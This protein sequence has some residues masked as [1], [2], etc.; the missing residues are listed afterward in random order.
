M[1]SIFRSDFRSFYFL[2]AT[3]FLGALNDN[4]FKLLVIYLLINLKGPSAANSILSLAGAIFVIPFLLFSS[5]AGVVADRISKRTIIV[6]TK[7]FEVCI[8]LFGMLA[9][10]LRWEVG[11]YTALFLMAT[12]SAIFGP[13]KYG[14]I[15]ELVE[16]KMVSK[17]NGSLTS[18]TY[19]AI[20]LGT[21]LASFLTDISGKNFVLEA[22]VCVLI[23][24][25]GLMASFGINRTT[26]Q[27][28]SKK[29]NPVFLY[30]IYQ[31]L[32]F[33]WKIP[34]LL[35]MIYGSSFFLFIGAFTQL[36]IIPFAMQSLGLSEV[37]GGYL[38]L[39]TAV[40]IAIG[41]VLSGLL[42][43]DR[44]EPGISCICGFFIAL[45]FFLLYCFAW[46][47]TMTLI[48]LGLL[49]V[50]GGAY[51]IPFDSFLQ[52]NSPK[53][54]RG[55]VIAAANFFSFIGVLMASFALY[56]I[57]EKLGFSAAS[58]FF[59]MAMITFVSN[60]VTTGRL[61]GL[62]FPFFVNKILKRFRRL[63]LTSEVPHPSTIIILESNSWYDAL[64]LFSCLPRLKLLI[65]GRYFR[66]FPWFNGLLESIQLVPPEPDMRSTL[67]NLFGQAKRFQGQNS[68]VCLFF[69]KR[70]DSATIIDAYTKIFGK[71]NLEIQF[72][73][74][75]TE[76]IEKRFLFF[77]YY[78]KQIILSFS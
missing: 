34:H 39:P 10:S 58:G 76:K 59:W 31:T 62:F 20:I 48:L 70:E 12:Q 72:A 56:L 33:S 41:A 74:G 68:S 46:S 28:S 55:Q 75:K 36:N 30:E 17:A 61:S 5:G 7:A 2:N 42:S 66:V 71:L 32:K 18:F 37:G 14:I 52:L 26:P 21:F 49:G 64:L 29:V 25:I 11:V 43:K 8:M 77:R 44:V 53:E 57:S 38:F 78:Q 69:Y 73:Y 35:P 23:A 45:F 24:G 67:K 47:L 60:V 27:N 13:S 4:V 9:I 51:L 19:L 65:P 22:S 16:T 54:K 1:R 3:Q 63:K 50:F 15:P 6:F 40:G